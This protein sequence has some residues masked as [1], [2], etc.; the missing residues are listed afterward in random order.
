MICKAQSYLLNWSSTEWGRLQNEH[1]KQDDPFH[2]GH[3]GQNTFKKWGGVPTVQTSNH[4][5]IC[6]K[7]I[8]R[9]ETIDIWVPI[10]C[11]S[12]SSLGTLR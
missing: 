7:T 1:A 10:C 5:F 9:I 11:V 8:K 3:Y 4:V 2:S 6:K 12:P